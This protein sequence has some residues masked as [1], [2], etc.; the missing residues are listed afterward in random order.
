V[1][2]SPE[3]FLRRDG[4]LVETRPI[5]GTRPRGATP[6]EDDALAADLATSE[7][8]R[9]ENVMIVDLLRN[10]LSRVCADG[11]IEV[12]VLCAV[13]RFATVMHLVSTVTGR[14]RPGVGAVDLL[15]ACFPGG[16]I[17]GAPKIRAMQIIAELEATRR[18]PYCG[19]IGYLGFDGS[20]D[21]SIVIR[22]FAIRG[23]RVTFQA[24]GGVVA[25]SVPADEYEETLAKARALVAALSP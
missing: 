24:G 21:T 4:D 11:S 15:A 10:D 22:T 18:G 19:A 2:S 17:T 9:S 23:R 14:L 16:S 12:P 25:D 1:S 13:E 6:A 3:R 5:K 7:K 20:L 8:D